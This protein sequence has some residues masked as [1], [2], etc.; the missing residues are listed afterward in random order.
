M[1]QTVPQICKLDH[2]GFRML[3]ETVFRLS[4]GTRIPSMIVKFD[5]QE[6]VLSLKSV[7]REF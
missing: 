6:A 5:S 7:A 3:G 2:A 1:S 4:E